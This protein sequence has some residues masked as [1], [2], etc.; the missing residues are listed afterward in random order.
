M[1]LIKPSVRNSL[2]SA[3]LKSYALGALNC[4]AKICWFFNPKKK[5]ENRKYRKKFAMSNIYIIFTYTHTHIYII[6]QVWIY[7]AYFAWSAYKI[8]IKLKRII[9]IEQKKRFM[10]PLKFK[11]CSNFLNVYDV[12]FN[13]IVWKIA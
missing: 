9:M 13:S 7:G 5:K 3:A 11:F 4:I 1:K 6:H 10:D 2:L 8:W 12:S